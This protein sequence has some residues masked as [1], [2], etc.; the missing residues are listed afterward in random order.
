M[1]EATAVGESMESQ[2]REEVGFSRCLQHV[3]DLGGRLSELLWEEENIET[4]DTTFETMDTPPQKR[5]KLARNLCVLYLLQ[6]SQSVQAAMILGIKERRAFVSRKLVFD[7]ICQV[8]R[9]HLPCNWRRLRS[10]QSSK[11]DEQDAA[12]AMEVVAM[13]MAAVRGAAVVTATPVSGSERGMTRR[14]GS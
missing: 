1:L 11:T 7:E 2:I 8:V 3:H 5:Q 9:E 12:V 6:C 4:V 14:R 10:L 13:H